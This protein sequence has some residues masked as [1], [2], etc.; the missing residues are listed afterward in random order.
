MHTTRTLRIVGAGL[1][2]AAAVTLSIAGPAY[3]VDPGSGTTVVALNTGQETTD[4]R[5]GAHGLF[6]YRIVGDQLCYTLSVSGLSAPAAAAH[7]HL[8]PRGVAGNIVI[9]LVVQPE[10]DFALTT[11]VTDADVPAVAEDPSLYYV[12]VHTSTYPG[13]EV[14]GQLH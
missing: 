3:A 1:A 11:C 13:G 10:T 7:I 9:P 8:A 5:G 4:A 14:R 2:A 6:S 12:N